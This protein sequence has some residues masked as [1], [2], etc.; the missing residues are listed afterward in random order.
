MKIKSKIGDG[1]FISLVVFAILTLAMYVVWVISSIWWPAV[2]LTAVLLLIIAP[3]YFGTYYEF[4]RS[5]LRVYSGI[6]GKSIPY[7]SIISMTDADSLAPAFCLSS[8]RILIRYMENEKIKSTYVSP[9]NREQFRDLLNAE[10]SKSTEIYREIPKTTMDMAV[11]K[12]RNEQVPFTPSQERAINTT[13]EKELT[14]QLNLVKK[15]QKAE[16]KQQKAEAKALAKEQKLKQKEERAQQKAELK[17][18]K[19]EKKQQKAEK[20]PPAKKEDET[21]EQQKERLEA[22]KA[23]LKAAIDDAKKDQIVPSKKQQKK[24]EQ[25]EIKAEEVALETEQKN[26]KKS[27]KNEEEIAKPADNEETAGN[28]KIDEPATESVEENAE[29]TEEKAPKNA[30]TKKAKKKEK[31]EEAKKSTAVVK[32]GKKTDKK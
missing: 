2:A 3:I 21:P 31:V 19:A 10:I 20:L 9:A 29:A 6:L 1:A 14:E 30:S 13:E 11:E 22:E 25:E 16:M 26:K 17:K 28:A 7:R 23:R 24:A 27:K 5:E 4:T 8:R 12:A 32:K 15:A 18:A